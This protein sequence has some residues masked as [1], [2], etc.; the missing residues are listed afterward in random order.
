M[1]ERQHLT[2]LWAST[3]VTGI[4]LLFTSVQPSPL[5]STLHTSSEVFTK[6]S[7]RYDILKHETAHS[8]VTNYVT[9][10]HGTTVRCYRNITLEETMISRLQ[11]V[12]SYTL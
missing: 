8:L 10:F 11:N 9:Y 4:H 2:T 3:P 7:E 6:C 5:S 12:F 1:W